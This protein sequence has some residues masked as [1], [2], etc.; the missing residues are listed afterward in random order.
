MPNV[1]PEYAKV[2]I[3]LRDAETRPG[4]RDARRACAR[5]P[6][7][8]ALAAD[9]ESTVNVQGG[10]WNML[11][12]MTGQRPLHANLMW[13][14]PLA[15]HRRRAAVRARDPEGDGGRRKRSRSRRSKPFDAN[16]GPPEGGSTDVGD[17]SWKFPTI[18][19]S[20]TTAPRGAPWH[21]WPVVACGGMSIGHKGMMYASK[22]LAATMIDLFETPQA[23]AAV[24]RDF[25]EKTKGVDIREYIP[26]GPPELPPGR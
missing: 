21:G 17:V 24:Q 18:H 25:A 4:R 6:Q 19:I 20:V 8:A 11:V 12:N 22:A 5:S 1:V 16:P 13:L 15:V 7:G 9:V 14:G 2:W 3:W 10:D 23:L 26:A